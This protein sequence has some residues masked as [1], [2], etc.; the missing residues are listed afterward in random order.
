MGDTW[1]RIVTWAQAWLTR[2]HNR[3]RL[4]KEV[5]GHRANKSSYWAL[6]VGGPLDGEEALGEWGRFWHGRDIRIDGHRYRVQH[7]P[8]RTVLTTAGG[9]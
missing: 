4:A 3:L 7:D 8:G 5:R 2:Y 1:Y 6:I 9:S